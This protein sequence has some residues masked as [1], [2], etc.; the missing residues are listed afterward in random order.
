MNRL[1]QLKEYLRLAQLQ[2]EENKLYIQDLK[3]SIEMEES[4]L[5][6]MPIIS[7]GFVDVDFQSKD[8]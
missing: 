3:A 6:F 5:Q 7:R 8:T 1:N 2:P 4:K